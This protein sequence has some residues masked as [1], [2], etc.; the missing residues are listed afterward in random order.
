MNNEYELKQLKCELCGKECFMLI[1][2][3]I[4]T[5]S[6]GGVKGICNKCFKNG[7]IEDKIFLK[8]K[9]FI[10]EQIESAVER[11]QFWEKELK[12]LF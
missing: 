2:I 12:S 9:S 11:K 10:E 3:V 5:D 6:F 8:Q 4:A 1:H 7:K